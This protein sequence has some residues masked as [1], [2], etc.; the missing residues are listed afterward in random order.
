M[1]SF[2]LFDSIVII[3]GMFGTLH[4][5]GAFAN[6]PHLIVVSLGLLS[7]MICGFSIIFLALNRYV[8]RVDLQ[9]ERFYLYHVLANA[10]PMIYFVT[11]LTE[12]PWERFY[13]P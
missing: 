3:I 13:A 9:Q 6:A 7:S 8:R 11:H 2:K 1:R 5:F 12:T 10:I 4:T